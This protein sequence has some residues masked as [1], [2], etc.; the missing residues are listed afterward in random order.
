MIAILFVHF[1]SSLAHSL[2]SRTE[3]KK[4]ETSRKQMR[5]RNN[6][7]IQKQWYGRWATLNDS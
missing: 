3:S 1:L 2:H 6:K 4:N 7:K 5:I